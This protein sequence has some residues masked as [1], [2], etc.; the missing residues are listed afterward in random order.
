MSASSR[1]TRTPSPRTS[2]LRWRPRRRRGARRSISRAPTRR[3]T[4]VPSSPLRHVAAEAP[5]EAPERALGAA[6]PG[7]RTRPPALA[8]HA[9][10]G[11]AGALRAASGAAARARA[12]APGRDDATERAR[13]FPGTPGPAA[14]APAASPGRGGV[15]TE[16]GAHA[17]VAAAAL[18]RACPSA[19]ALHCRGA[20]ASARRGNRARARPTPGPDRARRQRAAMGRAPRARPRSVAPAPPSRR[21]PPPEGGAQ[22]APPSPA[23][24]TVPHRAWDASAP[25]WRRAVSGARLRYASARR[26]SRRRPGVSP[27]RIWPPRSRPRSSASRPNWNRKSTAPRRCGWPTNTGRRQCATA[28][29]RSGSTI[30][31]SAF[32]R[33]TTSASST[34]GDHTPLRRPPQHCHPG[35]H[36]R[37]PR[38]APP[39]GR[40]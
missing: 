40:P 23:Q 6:A 34:R 39:G 26:R 32:P 2:S 30:P 25:A 3:G 28:R 12:V 37:L 14:R 22:T 18:P 20:L 10:R 27:P 36:A 31:A 9:T 35:A 1:R 4:G 13:A 8:L 38:S 24:G 21:A 16:T 11:G 5:T 15:R 17:G 7:S 19:P 33:S 29:S